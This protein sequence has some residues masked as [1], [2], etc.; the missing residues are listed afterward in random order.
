MSCY[1]PMKAFVVGTT[2]SGKRDLS[3]QP[4]T[5]DYVVKVN[6]IWRPR[7][8]TPPLNEVVRS[9]FVTIPC[10]QCMGCRIDYSRQW[11]NRMMLELSY[12]K[13]AWFVTLTYDN[14]HLPLTFS[15]PDENGEVVELGTLCKRDVQLFMKRLR[16]NTGQQLRFYLAGEYGSSSARPHYH[17]IIYGLHLPADDLIDT[18]RSMDGFRYYRS[19]IVEQAWSARARGHETDDKYPIS[20]IGMVCVAPVSWETCAYTARYVAKK[21]N[22]NLAEVYKRNN[23]VPEFSL[24][25]RRP[26]IGLQYY[27]DHKDEIYDGDVIYLRTAKGGRKIKPPRY[28]DMKFDLDCPEEM[29]QIHS[30]RQKVAEDLLAAKLASTDKSYLELLAD[31]ESA[32]KR[33][34]DQLKKGRNVV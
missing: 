33:K 4:Y 32:F 13:D 6:G 16:K 1:H 20:L 22:G 23:L 10:G 30:Q 11:A 28:Y 9:D 29:E 18:G 27:L 24:M 21:L 7:C 26:G 34:F 31:E 15:Q 8:G 2:S 17:C 12:H 3:I 25:S 19:S 5:A 14:A